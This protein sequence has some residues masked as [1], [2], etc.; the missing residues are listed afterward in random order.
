MWR[1]KLG[2]LLTTAQMKAEH[3][4]GMAEFAPWWVISPT[5]FTASALL[6]GKSL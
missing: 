1:E 3:W 4:R 2:R 6:F 5:E